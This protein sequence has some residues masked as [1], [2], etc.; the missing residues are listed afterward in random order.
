MVVC[1]ENFN[2]DFMFQ[3]LLQEKIDYQLM[4]E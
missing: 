4:K 1:K 2:V 3:I